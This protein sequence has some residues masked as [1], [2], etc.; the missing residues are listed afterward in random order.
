M[1]DTIR[2]TCPGV[3]LS[4]ECP[5]CGQASPAFVLGDGQHSLHKCGRCR[6]LYVLPRLTPEELERLYSVDYAGGDISAT[7]LEFRAP[8]FQ[9]CL[10]TLS[11]LHTRKGALLDVGCWTGEFLETASKD[12]WAA[13]GIEVSTQAA[14]FATSKGRDVQCCTLQTAPLAAGSFDAVT[15]LDVLEHLPEPKQELV[16]AR[17]LLKI[18]GTL[19]VRVPNT[20]FHLPK[21][22]LLRMCGIADV[23]L[24][25]KYHLNHF[26]P[27]T[28]DRALAEAGFRVETMQVGAP[29]T[30]AHS[31]WASP[32]LKR[33]YVRTAQ[34][35][36]AITG[37]HAG[38][39]MVAYARKL[40]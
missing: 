30:I 2:E 38:N 36:H 13:T 26:T 9:Q 18:G 17:E 23:G 35:L 20:N 14:K 24:Q 4:T 29:E 11:R 39:I 15:F 25:M 8:V 5:L 27:G 32:G 6:F 34:L 31:K 37:L 7:T 10:S 16:R 19:V 40:C 1:L 22:H 33:A 3:A 21:T 28:L 12:G